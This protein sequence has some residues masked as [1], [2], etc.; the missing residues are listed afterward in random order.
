MR[1]WSQQ[2]QWQD[3][4]V[5]VSIGVQ[6]AQNRVREL[7]QLFESE[8]ALASLQKESTNQPPSAVHGD[9]SSLA[10]HEELPPS[11]FVPA[12]ACCLRTLLAIEPSLWPVFAESALVGKPQT[13]RDF[14]PVKKIKTDYLCPKRQNLLLWRRGQA[15]VAQEE[16]AFQLPLKGRLSAL[17]RSSADLVDVPNRR[18]GVD[19]V[20][21]RKGGSS[22]GAGVDQLACSVWD[23]GSAVDVCQTVEERTCRP[24]LSNQSCLPIL[25]FVLGLLQQLATPSVA[26]SISLSFPE[27]GIVLSLLA[28][29]LGLVLLGASQTVVFRS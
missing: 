4:L 9:A 13:W 24:T 8:L 22:E 19:D 7:L 29:V 20:R 16:Q 12:L 15:N 28:M 25:G 26:V 23:I 27:D 6:D 17:L 21:V 14:M 3:D 18:N 11:L 10:L 2:R 5:Q 1:I